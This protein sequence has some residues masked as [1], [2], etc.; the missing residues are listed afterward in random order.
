M[1]VPPLEGHPVHNYLRTVIHETEIPDRTPPS[2]PALRLWVVLARAHAA[3]EA[4]ARADIARHGLGA[5]EF[6][7]LEALYHRGPL[8]LGEVQ[9]KVLLSSGGVTYVIDRLE[10]KGLVERRPCPSDR[11]AVYAALT[12][13]GEETMARIFPAHAAC[14]E[15]VL[16]G[17]GPED[18]ERAA[19]LLRT[20]GLEAARLEPTGE[21]G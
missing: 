7:V 20:L 15:R 5:T 17:L 21:G 3:I 12:P 8:L 1:A 16:S 11:R 18:Q 13:R 2:S 9:Q 6:G 4:H 14:M 10:E 19:A